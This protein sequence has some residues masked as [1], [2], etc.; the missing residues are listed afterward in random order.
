MN[1]LIPG[2]SAAPDIQNVESAIIRLLAQVTGSGS[3]GGQ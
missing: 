2:T 1:P 3:E